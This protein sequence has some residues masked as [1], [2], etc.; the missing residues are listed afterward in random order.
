MA[1]VSPRTPLERPGAAAFV[2]TLAFLVPTTAHGLGD[3]TTLSTTDTHALTP[4]LVTALRTDVPR[5]AVVFADLETSYRISAYAPVYVAAAPPAH[6]A[7]SGKNRPQERRADVLAFLRTTDL[8]IPRRYHATW[9]VLAHGEK[10]VKGLH[11]VYGDRRFGLYRIPV[12][13]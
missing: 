6:V 5:G 2:G 3:W 13:G 1:I 10:R 9:L 7:D 8:A 4:G 11:A 12:A